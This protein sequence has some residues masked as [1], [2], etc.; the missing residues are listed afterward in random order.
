[1]TIENRAYA[2]GFFELQIDG[3]DK[4][5]YLKSVEGG[6]V[7]GTLVDEAIGPDNARIK[8]MSTVEVDPISFEYSVAGSKHVIQW[9]SDSWNKTWNTRSGQITHATFNGKTTFE[10]EFHDALIT[11]ASFPTLDGS[12][13]EP[14]YLKVKIQPQR[15]V[16]RTVNQSANTKG[17]ATKIHKAWLPSSFRFTLNGIEGL[18]YTN[19]IE[20]FTI[21]Q[22]VKKFFTGAERLPQIE[23]TKIEYPNISGTISL[24]K[25][26]SLLDWYDQYVVKGRRDNPT[27]QKHGM[28][29]FLSPDRGETLFS[30]ILDQVGI[31]QAQIEAV[32]AG[33]EAIKRVKFELYV[34]HME[35]SANQAG[36]VQS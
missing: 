35:M 13:K 9:I 36:F 28:I 15:I 20:G 25:A 16:T 19:K 29:E 7:K 21:K 4:T 8:H 6:F 23:P 22:G 14:A 11:E 32:K 3:H 34:G 18:E 24:D 33:A 5:M 26:G 1:M 17:G 27:W 2:A 31:L 12:S 30:I 10:H